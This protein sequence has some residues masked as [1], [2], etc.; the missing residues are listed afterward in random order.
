MSKANPPAGLPVVLELAALPREQIGPFIIL[1]VDKTA[2]KEQ[3][4]AAWAQR[5]IW[6]RK[7]QIKTPLEDINWAREIMNDHDRRIRADAASLNMDTSEGV[8][9]RLG[10][11]F[12]GLAKNETAC[13]PLDVE[14]PLAD[15]SPAVEVPDIAEER[16]AIPVGEVPLEIP[17]VAVL[18]EELLREPLDP[19]QV[20]LGKPSSPSTPDFPSAPEDAAGY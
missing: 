20:D 3:I 8:L 9:R 2:G 4:E 1:G 12:A 18:V 17:A 19:W 13:R 15:Y 7:E 16:R 6:A 10:E 11:R 14:L 5:V